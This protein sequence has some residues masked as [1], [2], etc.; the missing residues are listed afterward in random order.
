MNYSPTP[1]NTAGVVI[2][3]ELEQLTEIIAKNVH[4]NW[5]CRRISEGWTYSPS[6]YSYEDK[7]TPCLVPYE[8]LPESEKDYDRTTAMETIRLILKLGYC[9]SGT[10][11]E[12]A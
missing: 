8:E 1:I 10:D 3:D 12:K 5:A 9:I 4:E 2:P 11:K 6:S 7:T